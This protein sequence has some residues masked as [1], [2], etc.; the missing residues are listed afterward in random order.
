MATENP[1][2]VRQ[3][4]N[5]FLDAP[6]QEFAIAIGEIAAAD[7]VLHQGI[8]AEDAPGGGI[9][10]NKTVRR[11]TGHGFH[12]EGAAS[13]FEGGLAGEYFVNRVVLHSEVNPRPLFQMGFQPGDG[14]GRPPGENPAPVF[15]GETGR[16]HHVIEVPVGQQQRVEAGAHVFQP[17]GHAFRGIDGDISARA[18]EEVA[19]GKSEAAGVAAQGFLD[20][21]HSHGESD[22]LFKAIRDVCTKFPGRRRL[23]FKSANQPGHPFSSHPL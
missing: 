15:A 22:G 7:P 10:K 1:V 4:E 20:H 3:G 14:G 13:R 6:D 12:L 23:S 16:I 18:G 9:D 8:P 11:V 5:F 17:L 19:I 2:I 21:L